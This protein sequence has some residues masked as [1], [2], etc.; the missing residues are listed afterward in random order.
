MIDEACVNDEEAHNQQPKQG[1]HNVHRL[2]NEEQSG[3][4]QIPNNSFSNSRFDDVDEDLLASNTPRANQVVRATQSNQQ[5]QKISQQQSSQPRNRRQT[6]YSMQISKNDHNKLDLSARITKQQTHLKRDLSLLKAWTTPQ[7]PKT[8]LKVI[9]SNDYMQKVGIEKTFINWQRLILLKKQSLLEGKEKE[10]INV[11]YKIS[12]TSVSLLESKNKGLIIDILQELSQN[13]V[14]YQEDLYKVLVQLEIIDDFAK[15]KHQFKSFLTSKK[16]LQETDY[17]LFPIQ[18]RA[19]HWDKIQ[20][21]LEIL[22]SV[23]FKK[24]EKLRLI[25]SITQDMHPLPVNDKIQAILN[26]QDDLKLERRVERPSHSPLLARKIRHNKSIE[27]L[28]NVLEKEKQ[29]LKPKPTINQNSK[30]LDQITKLKQIIKGIKRNNRS[31]DLDESQVPDDEDD[32]SPIKSFQQSSQKKSRRDTQ[33]SVDKAQKKNFT[34]FFHRC[35][36]LYRDARIRQDSEKQSNVTSGDKKSHKEEVSQ[37]VNKLLSTK[38][39]L[40]KNEKGKKVLTKSQSMIGR[41]QY[42]YKKQQP[43]QLQKIRTIVENK[44]NE[45]QQKNDNEDS[46]EENVHSQTSSSPQGGIKINSTHLKI[47]DYQPG[48]VSKYLKQSQFSPVEEYTQEQLETERR[49]LCLLDLNLGNNRRVQL[50]IFQGDELNGVIK[51][52]KSLHNLNKQQIDVVKFKL[53]ELEVFKNQYY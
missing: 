25:S 6:N 44:N 12:E 43:R 21:F 49:M 33:K 32:I 31:I 40:S 14:L 24:N 27:Y 4:T 2:Y 30:Q 15:N 7:S 37:E 3:S 48:D 53:G 46:D 10:L 1:I 20:K 16:I 41:S 29:S 35:D 23:K 47:Q 18:K 8:D 5:D 28:H 36:V 26:Y 39:L 34:S 11:Q 13:D 19:I 45:Q 51:K 17:L 9:Y 22:L 38:M 42:S 50:Q 52:L